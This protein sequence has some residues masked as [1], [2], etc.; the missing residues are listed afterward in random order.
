MGKAK[1][2]ATWEPV[3]PGIYKRKG[4]HGKPIYRAVRQA[5]KTE[6]GKYLQEVATFNGEKIQNALAEAR[7]WKA[8]AP[9]SAR[10]SKTSQWTLQE[11]YDALHAD[12]RVRYAKSTV[13]WH[14]EM[15]RA[16]PEAVKG[17]QLR[18]ITSHVLREHLKKIKAPVVRDRVRQLVGMMYRYAD[19]SP[20]PAVKEYAPRTRATRMAEANG[21]DE[22]RYRTDSEVESIVRN[23]DDER[24]ASLV[25]LLWRVGLRPGEAFAL[26]VGQINPETRR[27]KI[28][29]AV[30][31]RE[32]GPTKTGKTRRPT[33]PQTV[34]ADLSKHIRRYSDWNDPDALVFTTKSGT[35]IDGHNFRRRTFGPAAKRAGVN[36]GIRVYDLRHTAAS[37][38]V[39]AGVDLVTVAEM[40]GHSVQVLVSTYAHY[41][42]EA[43]RRAADTLDAYFAEVHDKGPTQELAEVTSR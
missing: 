14:A 30:N 6:E 27:L 37:N 40:T 31:D 17:M 35:M 19:V 18:A 32:V 2:E 4:R 20:S 33:L 36:G 13:Q 7:R 16:L 29:R 25:R 34:F 9:G 43:G 10:V 21:D 1:M 42:E 39:A 24:Y 3:E 11:T 12:S 8:E 26:T 28:D 38:M 41:V 5:G 15:W 22:G 23:L